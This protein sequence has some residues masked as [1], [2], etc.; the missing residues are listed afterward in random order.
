MG[1]RLCAAFREEAIRIYRN[2]L[3]VL[4]LRGGKN[5]AAILKREREVGSTNAEPWP[6]WWEP[7][8]PCLE[9]GGPRIGGYGRALH[10]GPIGLLLIG[11]GPGGDTIEMEHCEQDR[12]L[13]LRSGSEGCSLLD[14]FLFPPLFDPVAGQRLEP[15]VC[16]TAA[17]AF[18]E[19]DLP[20]NVASCRSQCFGSAER[21]VDAFSLS[22][23]VRAFFGS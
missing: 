4:Y 9:L 23:H 15:L 14:H 18:A 19:H 10:T 22:I 17:T 8:I 3:T 1:Y 13:T 2:K 5:K 7:A 16:T 11:L 20:K 6:N 21:F 12:A